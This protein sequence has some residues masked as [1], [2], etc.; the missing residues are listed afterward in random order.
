MMRG[1]KKITSANPSFTAR[2]EPNCPTKQCDR[3]PTVSTTKKPK[4]VQAP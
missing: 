4:E 2:N 1:K 3:V